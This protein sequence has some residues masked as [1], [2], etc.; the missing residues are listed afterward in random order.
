MSDVSLHI[1]QKLL[2]ECL[3]GTVIDI[4]GGKPTIQK[5]LTKKNISR[6]SWDYYL[7]KAPKNI[8][9]PTFADLIE[10]SLHG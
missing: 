6:K 5:I 2:S 7:A 9:M 1:F 10:E 3:S 4:L 8:P